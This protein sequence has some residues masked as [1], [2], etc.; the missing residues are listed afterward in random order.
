VASLVR[1]IT[2]WVD[3][4][5]LFG[6]HY[7]LRDRWKVTTRNDGKHARRIDGMEIEVAGKSV[8]LT[9]PAANGHGVAAGRWTFASA[10][11]AQK[12]FACLRQLG[13]KPQLDGSR[14]TSLTFYLQVAADG[15][16]L[17]EALSEK[18]TGP[19]ISENADC[20]DS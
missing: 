16:D 5:A 8:R 20:V 18:R 17:D 6:V 12:M 19:A 4:P 10:A 11:A 15:I 2:A 13:V 3:A 14:I 9:V 1:R 7:A